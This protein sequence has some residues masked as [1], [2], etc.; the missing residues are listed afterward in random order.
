MTRADVE[1]CFGRAV[2]LVAG[3]KEE[4]TELDNLSNLL[5]SLTNVFIQAKQLEE[6]DRKVVPAQAAFEVAR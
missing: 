3:A 1:E 4:L 6:A 5:L 2:E